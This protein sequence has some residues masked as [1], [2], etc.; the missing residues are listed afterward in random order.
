MRQLPADRI[1][2]VQRDFQFG[3]S[4]SVS[5][6]PNVD[7]WFLPDSIANIYAAGKQNDVPTVAGFT[8]DDISPSPLRLAKTLADYRDKA[9]QV[10][11][12]NAPR[13]LSLYPAASDADVPSMGKLA[14]RHAMMEKGTRKLAQAQAATGKAPFYMY[15][16]SRVHPFNPAAPVFDSPQGAYHT[17]D[18]PYW[19]QTQD[20][21]NMFRPTRLWGQQDRALS[22]RMMDS[23]LAFARTGNPATQA[24]PWP[25][26]RPGDERYVDFGDRV[27]VGHENTA[28]LDFQDVPAQFVPAGT[29]IPR[30]TRD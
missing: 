1:F 18:V 26:W 20:A 12:E 28:Q 17:S 16:F 21:L 30:L 5:V 3:D 22:A 4:G 6:K 10:Y 27:Q 13:F 29:A 23:L 7:G 24:T 9:G 14:A 11:G 2:V 15:V 19:F 25:A 8:A